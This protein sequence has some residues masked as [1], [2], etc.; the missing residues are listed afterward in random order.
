MRPALLALPL[1]LLAC[2]P[3]PLPQSDTP[4]ELVVESPTYGAFLGTEP[5]EVRGQVSDPTAHV[6]IEGQPVAVDGAG[7]FAVTLPI[8]GDYEV[9]D[10]QA[11]RRAEP[12][13][14]RRIPVFSGRP[15][16]ETFPGELPAQVTAAGLERLGMELG[17]AFDATGWAD[18]LLNALPSTRAGDLALE[19]LAVN[20]APTRVVLTGVENGIDVGIAIR[21]LEIV[22]NA[23][24]RVFGFEVEVPVTLGYGRV[25]IVAL[26]Q[27][28]IRDEGIVYLRARNTRVDLGDA[29]VSIAGVEIQVVEFLL[30]GI[31]FVVEW[32]GEFLG[33]VVL[34]LL[35]EVDLGGPFD[36]ESDLMGTQLS[37]ALR[38]VWGDT[39]GLALGAT[40]GIDEPAP[41][42][43]LNLP[44]P[45]PSTRV[46]DPVHLVLG[47]HEGLLD[48]LLGGAIGPALEQELDLGPFAAILGTVVGNL[49]GGDF[50]PETNRWCLDLVPGPASVVRLRD[51]IR[52]IGALYLPDVTLDIGAD[53]G[54]GCEPW[55]TANLAIEARINA[56]NT[57]LAVELAIGEG[58]VMYYGA[59]ATAW[60]EDDVV[61]ELAGLVGTLGG[62]LGGALSFDLAE[63]IGGLGGE[64][65]LGDVEPRIVDSQPMLDHDGTPVEGMFAVSLALWPLP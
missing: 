47:V 6:R 45:T 22:Y 23:K 12:A 19:P 65:F 63:L 36:F 14:R 46:A 34:D 32:L 15:P 38:Q 35:G 29:D 20:H 21:D 17:A 62:A 5:I 57:R 53:T 43:A 28:A 50:A 27:P 33:D 25:G 31:G 13:V 24:G 59:P 39:L 41:Y 11:G 2:G 60:R 4:L 64:G 58:A 55:I 52:P 49:P 42:R 61:E 16:A 7:R 44:M 37:V 30:D 56:R 18:G 10:I 8:D 1:A 54:A 26:T 40:V 3:D 9:V 48:G 51:G